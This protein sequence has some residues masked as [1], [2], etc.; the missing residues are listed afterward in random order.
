[1]A[2]FDI[3]DYRKSLNRVRFPDRFTVDDIRAPTTESVLSIVREYI[4]DEGFDIESITLNKT[5]PLV[6]L[7]KINELISI[8]VPNILIQDYIHVHDVVKIHWLH[9][10]TTI[11][12]TRLHLDS[13]LLTKLEKDVII[14]TIN[15]INGTIITELI[16]TEPFI[17]NINKIGMIKIAKIV[18]SL[19]I[20]D[21]TI[22][23]KVKDKKE[24]SPKI[25][26]TKR[27][28]G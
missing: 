10:F 9:F 5:I 22:K 7:I 20:G 28:E 16:S 15:F 21:K 23:M 12:E 14:E 1:L 4:E 13:W 8:Y 2:R 17:V 25:I 26:T 19:T 18:N 27:Y 6:D 24:E 3:L 11:V